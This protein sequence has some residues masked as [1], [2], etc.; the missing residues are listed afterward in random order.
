LL[1]AP[2]FLNPS[3]DKNSDWDEG[4]GQILVLRSPQT[5]LYTK[6]RTKRAAG[7]RH[8][9]KIKTPPPVLNHPNEVE[10]PCIPRAQVSI[11]VRAPHP[12]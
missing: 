11:A 10:N 6:E 2:L 4:R 9:V 7:Y 12:E 5:Y 1:T 8:K 3:G